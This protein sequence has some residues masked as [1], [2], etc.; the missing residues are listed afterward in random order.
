MNTRGNARNSRPGAIDRTRRE[1]LLDWSRK[2]L[3]FDDAQAA[4][5]TEDA[6][7]LL[8]AERRRPQGVLDHIIP[9]R[10]LAVGDRWKIPNGKAA[11]LFLL[12]PETV[13]GKKSRCL[14]KLM[15]ARPQKD[16]TTT[17]KIALVYTLALTK[18]W[19]DMEFPDLAVIKVVQEVVAPA[20]GESPKGVSKVLG[21][22]AVG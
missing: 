7:E 14:G 10:H 13:V 1:I 2:G 21:D 12:D 18:L 11:Q 22:L 17:L 8:E 3:E 4:E 15:S 16:G 19:E 6:R 5:L 9:S 20:E